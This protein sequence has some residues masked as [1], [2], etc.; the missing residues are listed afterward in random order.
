VY[1]VTEMLYDQDKIDLN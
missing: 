1:N